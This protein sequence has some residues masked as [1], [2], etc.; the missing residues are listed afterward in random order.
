MLMKPIDVPVSGRSAGKSTSNTS[1]V[2]VGFSGVT[3]CNSTGTVVVG[4]SVV[5]GANVVV[6]GANVVVVVDVVDVVL[7]VVVDTKGTV[8]CF[9]VDTT[10]P[11]AANAVLVTEPSR[12]PVTVVYTAVHCS[13]ASTASVLAAGPQAN[14]APPLI[15]SSSMVN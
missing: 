6:V 12:S 2:P 13:V 1:S 4:A 11:A 3:T 14:G 8:T 7:V 5:V 15:L 9:E 10:S